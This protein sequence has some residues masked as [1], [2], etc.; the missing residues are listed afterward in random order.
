MN[1]VYHGMHTILRSFKQYVYARVS[2][3][4]ISKPC[5]YGIYRWVTVIKTSW[6]SAGALWRN[7]T[8]KIEG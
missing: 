7:M 8:S 5:Q 4:I 6:N 3:H 1:M 2:F